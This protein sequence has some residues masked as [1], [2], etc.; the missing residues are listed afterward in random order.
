MRGIPLDARNIVHTETT[1]LDQPE[2]FL[3]AGRAGVF[4]P[5]TRNAR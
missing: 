2:Y 4:R 3:D 1:R 5:P